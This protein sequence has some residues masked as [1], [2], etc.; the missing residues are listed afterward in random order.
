[1]LPTG[2]A[3]DY[4]HGPGLTPNPANGVYE[5]GQVLD[6]L[7]DIH[8][9]TNLAAPP[10]PVPWRPF[11]YRRLEVRREYP[12]GSTLA[13]TTTYT[14]PEMKPRWLPPLIHILT[15]TRSGRFRRP[16]S[17]NRACN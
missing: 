6:K 13:L 3:I 7:D 10:A 15:M 5:S 8:L 14:G 9:G 4:D 16:P 17:A 2:G 1:V 12:N 11:I